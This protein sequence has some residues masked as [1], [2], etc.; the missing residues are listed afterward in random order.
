MKKIFISQSE[1]ENGRNR[2]NRQ[3]IA[4]LDNQDKRLYTNLPHLDTG[5][6]QVS[7]VSDSSFQPSSVDYNH[8]QI[9]KFF[10]RYPDYVRT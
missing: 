8:P 2:R 6:G 3:L 5:E 4:I 9:I 1:L 10:K 7:V